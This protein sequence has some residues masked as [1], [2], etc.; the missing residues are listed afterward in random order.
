MSTPET[1]PSITAADLPPS[2]PPS[3][4]RGMPGIYSMVIS[5]LVLCAML[6]AFVAIVPRPSKMD[7]LPVDG[8]AAVKNARELAKQP[9][10]ALEPTPSGW[11]ANNA[12]YGPGADGLRTWSIGYVHDD[13]FAGLKQVPAATSAWVTSTEQDFTRDGSQ[14]IDGVQW[15]RWKNPT[16]NDHL[17][18]KRGVG[19]AL[20]T[21]VT[22][23]V[24]YEDAAAFLA[25]LTPKP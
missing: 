12:V 5:M 3:R 1:R 6:F 24:S 20:T 2:P 25:R 4:R 18:L 23:S 13:H 14:Q 9:F 22:S 7:R 19:Q 21:A 15:E 8:V 16:T 11:S 10:S 17:L